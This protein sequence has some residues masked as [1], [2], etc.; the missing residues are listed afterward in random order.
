MD[1]TSNYVIIKKSWLNHIGPLCC[2][3]QRFRDPRVLHAPSQTF[4]GAWQLTFCG[5]E[6]IRDAVDFLL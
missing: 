4:E 5:Y 3:L 2:G 6:D 1:W